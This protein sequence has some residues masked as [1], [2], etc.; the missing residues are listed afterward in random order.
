MRGEGICWWRL[1]LLLAGFKVFYLALIS[2]A[3]VSG[4]SFDYGKAERIQ[5]SWFPENGRGGSRGKL[6]KHYTTWDGEHYL[7]LSE[8]GYSKDVKSCAFFPLWPL[9][10]RWGTILT[11]G[12]YVVAGMVLA[13]L[14]SIVGWC[15]YYQILL[16][17]FGSDIAWW[18]LWL[19]VLFPGSV[20]YQFIY[21]ESLFFL[22]VIVLW[23]GLEKRRYGTAMLAAFLLP[24]A[25][26]V[27]V[28][29]VIPIAWHWMTLLPEKWMPAWKWLRRERQRA[30]GQVLERPGEWLFRSLLLLMPA[31]GWGWYLGLM[32]HWTGNPFEGMQA[33]EYWG[34]TH[35]VQHLW[36]VPQFVD[37]FFKATSLHSFLGSFL[38]RMGFLLLLICLPWIWRQGKDLLAWVYMLGVVPA[39]SGTFTSFL[40]Y[41]SNVFPLFIALAALVVSF[42]CAWLR[43]FYLLGWAVLHGLLLWRFVNYH[44]AG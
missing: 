30:F 24:L 15:L 21:S 16:K 40:R 37:G 14:F 41:E 6:E 12:S 8:F 22:L 26:G 10:I 17:R 34:D 39:M 3:A 19:L 9:A 28:F 38:D 33:Q 4:S 29:G 13:N 36:D 1:F 7:Y 25:R 42:R 31:A 18:G 35:A 44:W 20:F 5:K 27:G 23:W 2:L 43:W 11:G 32:W